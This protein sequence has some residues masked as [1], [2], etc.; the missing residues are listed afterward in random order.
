MLIFLY[1]GYEGKDKSILY[2]NILV[3]YAISELL[4]SRM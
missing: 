4:F 2:S 3:A 1:Y